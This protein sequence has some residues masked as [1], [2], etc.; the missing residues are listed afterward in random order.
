MIHLTP[1]A[2][3]GILTAITFLPLFVFVFLKGQSKTTKLL[4]FHYF[5]VAGWG[6]GSFLIGIEQN[7]IAGFALWKWAYIFPLFIP[8]SIMHCAVEM[9]NLRY[10]K[11]ILGLCYAQAIFFAVLSITGQ[12]ANEVSLKFGIYWIDSRAPMY[13]SFFIWEIITAVAHI[14]L[15]WYYLKS[16]PEQK[17]Q[18]FILTISSIIGFVGGTMN[19]L[20]GFGINIYPWGNFLIPIYSIMIAYVVLQYQFMD[21]SFVLRKGAVYAC[22]IFLISAL[23]FFTFLVCE[24]FVK[25][26]FG[27]ENYSI[28]PAVI[29]AVFLTFLY[30]PMR[31]KIEYIVDATLFRKYNEEIKRQNEMMEH[32]LIRSEKFKMAAEIMRNV[33]YQVRNPL[34]AIKTRSLLILQR[35]NNTEFIEQS[36]KNIDEQVEKVNQLLHQLLKFSNP[37]APKMEQH[38]V[39]EIIDEVI[40]ILDQECINNGIK[41]TKEFLTK[42]TIFLRIDPVQFR[43]ALYNIINHSI[44]AMPVG[45]TL[46]LNTEIK[47]KY[48]IDLKESTNHFF[49]L[50]I[51]DTG[52]EIKKEELSHIFDPFYN[53]KEKDADLSLSIAHR[54]IKEH[55]GAI[56]VKSSTEGTIFSLYIPLTLKQQKIQNA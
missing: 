44:H 35:L 5:C 11:T 34:T 37:S 41:V 47:E 6:I 56:D 48:A 55:N 23:Y 20:P 7:K 10:K 40:T 12:L 8:V 15:F 2:I 39:Y 24:P 50:E 42:E 43:Q 17:K 30:G 36:A 1:Y 28:F 32:E 54:I 52:K 49:C 31:L 18:L 3:S 45:G 22:L 25:T 16:H 46:K 38:N 14:F 13:A 19:F 51:T 9:M 53:E 4:G 26:L 33:V 27:A 21:I 29:S